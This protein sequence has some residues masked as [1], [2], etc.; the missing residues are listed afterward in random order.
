M[1][2]SLLNA[3]TQSSSSL[4]PSSSSL[5]SFLIRSLKFARRS[6]ISLGYPIARARYNAVAHAHERQIE[7]KYLRFHHGGS[8]KLGRARTVTIV[9]TRRGCALLSLPPSLLSPFF[10][11]SIY[12]PGRFAHGGCPVG[13]GV[14]QGHATVSVNCRSRSRGTVGREKGTELRDGKRVLRVSLDT[15]PKET[16]GVHHG[17]GGGDC[18]SLRRGGS[19]PSPFRDRRIDAATRFTD[20]GERPFRSLVPPVPFLFTSF[21]I[22]SFVFQSFLRA[23]RESR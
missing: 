7:S 2:V 3:M 17:G 14:R 11:L 10:F 13:P 23:E 4:S 12:L 16:A 6:V 21:F 18:V 1:S 19:W 22:F 5:S 8:E 20:R 9:T 15:R